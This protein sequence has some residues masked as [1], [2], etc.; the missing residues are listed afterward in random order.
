MDIEK[1]KELWDRLGNE[2]VRAYRAFDAY[3][4]RRGDTDDQRCA[5]RGD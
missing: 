5:H 4:S 3:R 1:K 2:P